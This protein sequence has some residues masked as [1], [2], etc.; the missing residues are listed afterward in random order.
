MHCYL[1]DIHGDLLLDFA[2]KLTAT[3]EPLPPSESN[4]YLHRKRQQGFYDCLDTETPRFLK[5]CHSAKNLPTKEL[6]YGIVPTLLLFPKVKYCAL[7]ANRYASQLLKSAEPLPGEV[8]YAL[9]QNT[10]CLF[11]KRYVNH[12]LIPTLAF[13]SMEELYAAASPL[14]TLVP[15]TVRDMLEALE[16]KQ[17][18]QNHPSLAAYY[19]EAYTTDLPP[20]L[21][22]FPLLT[23]LRDSLPDT[24]LFTGLKNTLTLPDC[25]PETAWV[26]CPIRAFLYIH[27][28]LSHALASLSR[29]DTV[30]LTLES[31]EKGV[32]LQFHAPAPRLS[33]SP[34]GKTVS[35][36]NEL[37]TLQHLCPSY[38]GILTLVQYLLTSR[39]FPSPAPGTPNDCPWS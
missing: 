32:R 24:L 29:K 25:P 39:P 18:P 35:V 28:L 13:T 19:R 34:G 30:H 3:D 6:S 15:I 20:I 16:G 17:E 37:Y 38:A 31:W 11:R 7:F 14:L 22:L 10:M 2:R 36:E 12:H 8:A 23:K 21:D 1:F 27:L 5:F 4:T 9:G 33:L 26:R